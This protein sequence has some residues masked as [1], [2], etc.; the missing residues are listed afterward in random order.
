MPS[1]RFEEHRD[2]HQCSI[3]RS[4]DV[5]GDG[6]PASIPILLNERLV[7]PDPEFAGS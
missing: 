2:Y 1:D 4:V 6:E 5:A 7:A 3:A